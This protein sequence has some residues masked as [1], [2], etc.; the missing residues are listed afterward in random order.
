MKAGLPTVLSLEGIDA[1]ARA[2]ELEL[3][4]VRPTR[5]SFEIRVFFEQADARAATPTAGN[6]RYAGSIFMFGRGDAAIPRPASAPLVAGAAD[7]GAPMTLSVD[8]TDAL[9]S[10]PRSQRSVRVTLVA[11]DPKGA[12][13]AAPEIELDAAALVATG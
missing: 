8:V 13:I 7:P 5:A 3:R 12:A 6:P 10:I 9:R 11:V 2:V 4:G 1:H